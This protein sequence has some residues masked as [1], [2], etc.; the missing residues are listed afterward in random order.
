MRFNSA[1][2]RGRGFSLIEL[3]IVLSIMGLL[4][5]VVM[6][7]AFNMLEQHKAQLEQK[8]LVDFFQRQKHQAY[9]QETKVIIELAGTSV[10]SSLDEALEFEFIDADYQRIDVNELGR[11][12][13]DIISYNLRGR[14]VEKVLGDL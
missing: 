3:M 14:P 5:S 7:E 1:A 8:R 2:V 11:F 6:P 9:L 4:A 13:S 12:D 10:T